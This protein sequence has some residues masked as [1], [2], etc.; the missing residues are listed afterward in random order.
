LQLTFCSLFYREASSVREKNGLRPRMAGTSYSF[1]VS[2]RNE[3][4]FVWGGGHKNREVFR[5]AVEEGFFLI[6]LLNFDL[7]TLLRELLICSNVGA[8]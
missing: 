1:S 7:R 5:G 4:N 2:S 3:V 8:R 6:N